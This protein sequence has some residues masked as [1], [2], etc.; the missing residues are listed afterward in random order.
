MITLKLKKNADRRI[1]SGH[2]WVFS[3]ELI[4][5][6]KAE[7]GEVAQL[8]TF[9]DESL[10]LGYYNPNSLIAF[11]LLITETTPDLDF[12]T[13]RIN[14]AFSLRRQIFKKESD[15]I[16]RLVFGES[17][18]LPGLIID[19]YGDYFAVQIL[20]AG[21]DSSLELIRQAIIKIFPEAKGIILKNKS[22]LRSSE[23]LEQN[24]NIIYGD[25]PQSVICTENNIKIDIDLIDSQK[26][27]YFLD[28]KLNRKF[29]QDISCGLNVLDCYSNQGGFALNAVKG[30]AKSAVCVD[31]S[32]KALAQAERNAEINSFSNME[33]V[34]ADVPE[35]LNS[36]VAENKNFDLV[37][38][39]PPAFTKSRKTIPTAKAG[40]AKINRLGLKLLHDG[41][42]LV[43]SSCSYHIT[44]GTFT[45]IIEKE[46]IKQGKY[47]N[48]IY[49]GAQAPDHP[50]HFAMPETRYLK[51][52]VYQ[53]REF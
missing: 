2:L 53:I 38:L 16:Y 21:M 34:A 3:N 45:G 11:R 9:N 47:L 29:V 20:S 19:R 39:D 17:D 26:T 36:L 24:E 37:V 1:R 44:E 32:K 40:Y 6:P 15:N 13:D 46:A 52:Y 23:G 28:Q 7:A 27:G 8:L 14:K 10:G 4:E 31:I 18:F 50:V 35:Y 42:Y 22:A 25:I 41:A 33:F 51:F 48:L 49:R 30:G 5:L 43:S 12:F